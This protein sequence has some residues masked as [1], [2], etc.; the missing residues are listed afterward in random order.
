MSFGTLTSIDGS[1]G[2]PARRLTFIILSSNTVVAVCVKDFDRGGVDGVT[3]DGDQIPP[4]I[5]HRDD[6]PSVPNSFKGF[7]FMTLLTFFPV[8]PL[9]PDDAGDARRR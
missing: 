2:F 1:A 4:N 5:I 3:S 6:W 7:S 9:S 8:P